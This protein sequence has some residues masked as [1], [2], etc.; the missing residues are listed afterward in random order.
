MSLLAI[1]PDNLTV[2]EAYQLLPWWTLLHYVAQATAVLMLEIALN[3]QH[4]QKEV[5]EV[6]NYLRKAM[7]YVWCMT[8]E[9]LSAY[10]AWRTFRQ[11]LSAILLKYEHYGAV[12]IP[13]EASQPKRW[14]EDDE[15]SIRRTFLRYR[16]SW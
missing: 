15:A 4:L 6:M 5:G 1:M 16:N 10:R 2:H 14:T 13:E 7:S 3:C 9:S 11:L 8:S 12:D